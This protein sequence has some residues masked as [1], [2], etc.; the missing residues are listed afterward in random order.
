M[1]CDDKIEG[2]DT[3]ERGEHLLML[4]AYKARLYPNKEQE[5]KIVNNFGCV[6][7]VYN[8]FLAMRQQRYKETG[9]TM[10]WI[11]CCK[12]LTELKKR[13]QTAWLKEADAKSLQSAIRN[14]D[15]AYQK[16]FR[17]IKQGKKP[18]G[19]PQFKS[20]KNAKQSYTTRQGVIVDVSSGK[21]KLPKLGEIKCRGLRP[22]Q[23]SIVNATVSKSASGKYYISFCYE[24]E[25]DLP[26]PTTTGAVVGLDLG[27]S[28]FAVSSDGIEYPNPKY[29]RRSEKK[30]ARLQRQMSR[31]TKGSK[32]YE[33]ARIR[34]AR[35]HEHIA[36]QRKDMQHKLSTE[37]VRQ[38]DVICVEGMQIQNLLKK[39][40]FAKFIADTGWGEFR[41][42]LVYKADWY[43]KKT[44]L[45]KAAFP[46]NQICS[47]CGGELPD[48]KNPGI[49]HLVCPACGEKLDR[50]KN[51]ACN[52]LKQGLRQE[53]A[54]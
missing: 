50:R 38:Y 9:E 21:V 30:L 4:Y 12:H 13:P 7:F 16:F 47:K 42:Q 23:G 35:L 2:I 34:L 40:M 39:S 37:L 5:Q 8:Y 27:I 11:E 20:K 15:A 44:I 52:I 54:A 51:A 25:Q 46:S 17:N 49:Q 41:R 29:L 33:K 28:S 19:Y 26:K 43:G 3:E 36:N 31:K 32:N 22:M 14:L 10:G 18:T 1:R 24:L 53:T 6:R 45:T 48:G